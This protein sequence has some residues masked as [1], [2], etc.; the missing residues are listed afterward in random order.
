MTTHRFFASVL[1]LVVQAHHCMVQAAPMDDE[2]ESSNTEP[3]GMNN[4]HGHRRLNQVFF[5]D[6][7]VQGSTCIGLDC[8]SSESFGFDSLR[9]RENNLRIHFEDTSN[10][11]SFPS[12]DW[13]IVINDSFNG[14]SNY[15]AVEDSSAGRIPFLVEA[16][17]VENALVV[18]SGDK[19]F[20]GFGTDDPLAN[21][22]VKS[23]E[24]PAIRLE[25]DSSA[26]FLPKTWE[27]RNVGA[28]M[29]FRC[30]EKTIMSLDC[31]APEN[32]LVLDSSGN[33]NFN[34]RRR[35]EEEHEDGTT[36]TTTAKKSQPTHSGVA[37][38]AEFTNMGSTRGSAKATVVLPQEVEGDYMVFLT[39]RTKY[40]NKH[41]TPNVLSQTSK[42]FEI[43]LGDSAAD[44]VQVNWIIHHL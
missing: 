41:F 33:L 10:S 20:V 15:F 4:H 27:I 30:D 26:G 35:A 43:S 44:L 18:G 28:K 32:S 14:G 6:L 8:R 39:A 17:A 12:N 23:G 3:L 7:I 40:A 2:K 31:G 42:G 29:E 24:C 16:G 9:L 13:R 22:H 5:D 38:A 1:W 34:T 25:K 21:I 11:A 37:K 36:H 19:G